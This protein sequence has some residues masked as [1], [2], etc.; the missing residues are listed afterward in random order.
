[1]IKP[2]DFSSLS[3]FPGETGNIFDIV[4]HKAMGLE[5]IPDI[6][7]LIG[8]SGLSFLGFPVNGWLC[9]VVV[10]FFIFDWISISRLPKYR[11]SYGP[12]KPPVLVLAVFRMIPMIFTPPVFWVPL[13][14]L[15]CLLQIDAFWMEPNRISISHQEINTKKL[16]AGTQFKFIHLGDL[17]VERSSVREEKVNKIIRD[18][19]ADAILFSGDYLCLSSIRD[20]QS[21]AD[22]RDIL[23]QWKAPLGVYGVT[24]SPAVDLPEN[25]PDLLGGTPLK[26]LVDE[27]VSLNKGDASIQLIG[28]KC[29]HKPHLDVPRLDGIL[30][31]GQKGFHLLL[32][33]S[34][35]IAPQISNNGIDLQLAGHTHGGQVCLPFF[36]PVFTGSLYGLKFKSGR[37]EINN[38]TLYITRGIGMEG[39]SAPRVRFLC[40]P[41]IVVWL[42]NG[43]GSK[44]TEENG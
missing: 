1:L 14:I 12:I 36:G 8:L 9:L 18:I 15:G 39:L 17:H 37:Y 21:W 24:G 23:Q 20:K 30:K 44:E 19:E 28:L 31:E 22:L 2:E 5:K 27:S 26:L 7:F 42:I 25:F 3:R 13:E 41:E 38:L 10:A 29:T 43:I 16:P 11:R 6:L 4:L 35:D 33:H 32:H 40:P 34:P